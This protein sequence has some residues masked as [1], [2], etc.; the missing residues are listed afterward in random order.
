MKKQTYSQRILT[1]L[2][3]EETKGVKTPVFNVKVANR[4][5]R[6]VDNLDNTV[7]REARK[8]HA[9]NLLKKT[10]RGQFTLTAYGRKAAATV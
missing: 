1:F 3:N 2:R 6:N 4:R 7:M 10:S 9:S 8:L 5:F